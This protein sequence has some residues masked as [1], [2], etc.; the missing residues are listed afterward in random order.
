MRNLLPARLPKIPSKQWVKASESGRQKTLFFC[1]A[2]EIYNRSEKFTA[3]SQAKPR[4]CEKFASLF[5]FMENHKNNTIIYIC[6]GRA[7]F[8]ST[9]LRKLRDEE[10]FFFRLYNKTSSAPRGMAKRVFFF[11]CARGRRREITSVFMNCSSS[12]PHSYIARARRRHADEDEVFPFLLIFNLRVFLFPSKGRKA[13][14]A[15]RV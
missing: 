13:K 14:A 15:D 11:V 7:F 9:Q 5:S 12:G 3:P 10:F 1:A 6:F 2:S 4:H 8:F